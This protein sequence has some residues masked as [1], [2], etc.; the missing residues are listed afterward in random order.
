MIYVVL[1]ILLVVVFAAGWYLTR[2]PKRSPEMTLEEYISAVREWETKTLEDVIAPQ[3][4]EPDI[5][6]LL[7]E[8]NYEELARLKREGKI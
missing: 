6:K 1:F 8:E 2:P 3:N 4:T 5:K 7:E